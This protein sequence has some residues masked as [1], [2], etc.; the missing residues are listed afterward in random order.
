MTTAMIAL[1]GVSVPS[2]KPSA[3]RPPCRRRLFSHRWARL[4]DPCC[5]LRIEVTEL[6]ITLGG[7]AAV[8]T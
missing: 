4:F 2:V 8:K 1:C 6:A 5:S 3:R 7:S